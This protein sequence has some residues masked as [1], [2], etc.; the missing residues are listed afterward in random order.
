M[1]RGTDSKRQ[2]QTEGRN[3]ELTLEHVDLELVDLELV[4]SAVAQVGPQLP[5]PDKVEVVWTGDLATSITTRCPDDPPY[6]TERLGGEAHAM[7]LPRPDGHCILVVA[8]W[9]YLKPEVLS[10]GG[11]S[12]DEIEST[13]RFAKRALTH[14]GWHAAIHQRNEGT[15]NIRSRLDLGFGVQGGFM[16]SAGV[17]SE[18]FRVERALWN[19]GH[20]W[21]GSYADGLDETIP[22][23]RKALREAASPWRPDSPDAVWNAVTWHFHQLVIQLGYVAGEWLSTRATGHTIQDSAGWKALLPDSTWAELAAAFGTFP[24]ADVRG[25]LE[26]LDVATAQLSEVLRGWLS[27]LGFTFEDMPNETIYVGYEGPVGA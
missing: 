13:G 3:V 4:A 25:P 2:G 17:A 10:S 23:V 15:G 9:P 5:D 19:A 21:D 6:S 20:G 16:A 24:A 22:T 7:M 1:I 11:A 27:R 8:V 12:P 14:E 18:E 26:E